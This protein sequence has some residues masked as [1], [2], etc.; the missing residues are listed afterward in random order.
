MPAAPSN[1]SLRRQANDLLRHAKRV[2]NYRKDELSE[3]ARGRLQEYMVG[4]KRC[5]RDKSSDVRELEKFLGDT[6]AFLR[7]IGGH[8]YPRSG[9]VENIEMLFIAAIVAIGIRTYIIQPFQIPTNSMYPTYNGM[10]F[11][12][13]EGDDAPGFIEKAFYIVDRAAGYREIVAPVSGELKLPVNMVRTHQN[14]EFPVLRHQWVG[15]RRMLVLPTQAMEYTMLVGNSPVSVTVPMDFDFQGVLNEGIFHA[16]SG[17]LT[18]LMMEPNNRRFEQI[19]G[20][21]WWNTGK[22]YQAGEPILKFSIFTG[23]A[24]FVDRFSYHFVRPQVGDPIVFR[25]GQIKRLQET[26]ESDKYYIKRMAGEPGDRLEIKN[27]QLWRNG[28]RANANQAFILNNEAAEVGH[29]IDR[30]RGYTNRGILSDGSVYTVPEDH[31][32]GLG[33]NSHNSSDSRDFGP[34]PRDQVIGRAL[35]RYYPFSRWGFPD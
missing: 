23:D 20:Q 2:W 30:Y 13:Y 29:P 15:S 34:I 26:N 21:Y 4:L 9:L 8:Y 31:V 22:F 14:M 7:S 18:Q 17:S 25:T 12:V 11:E 16:S 6:E 33:D 5:A 10:T 24:L 3:E 28:H 35:F 1:K 32:I 19:G 27:G